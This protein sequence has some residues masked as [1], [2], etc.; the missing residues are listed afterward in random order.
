VRWLVADSLACREQFFCSHLDSYS[1]YLREAGEEV[2]SICLNLA[3]PGATYV[4]GDSLRGIPGV[5]FALDGYDRVADWASPMLKPIKRIAQVAAICNPM[6]WE[7]R[8]P[9]GSPAYDLVISSLNWMV[10]EA[11]KHGCRAE[12]M[13]LAF[14]TRARVCGMGVERENKA[15]FIGTVG[16]NHARRYELLREL[17]DVVQILPPVYGREYFRSLAGATVLVQPHAEWARGEANSMK[18]YEGAGA[19]CR[20]VSDGISG[21]GYGGWWKTPNS[22]DAASWREAIK[23]SLDDDNVDYSMPTAMNRVLAYETYES[24][25]PRLIELA[26]SL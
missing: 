25:I 7:V 21:D 15:I 22:N 23:W 4:K 1:H 18:L 26:R 8:K 13:P 24:R 11:R 9:D 10:D 6:P 12:Y 17:A 2:D 19:G 16:S 3:A 20:V 5:I 14:D